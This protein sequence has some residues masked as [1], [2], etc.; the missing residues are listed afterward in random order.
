[1]VAEPIKFRVT[2]MPP[3]KGHVARKKCEILTGQWY[4]SIDLFIVRRLVDPPSL[5]CDCVRARC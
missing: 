1:M 2:K 5:S 4:V 3:K